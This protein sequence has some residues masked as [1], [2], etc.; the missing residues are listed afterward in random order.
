MSALSRYVEDYLRLRRALGFKL[1]REGQL[2]AQLVA[3]LETAGAATITTE[4]ATAWARQPAGVQPNHWAKRLGVV[5]KFAA[6]L[7]TIDPATEVPPPG[8]FPARRRRPTPY[9]WSQG[10]IC[11]LLEGARALRSPLRAATHEA[12]FGLLATSGMRVGEAIGLQRDDVGLGAGVITI[13]EA[14]FDRSRLVPLHPSATQALRRYAAERDRL[15]PRPRS[16]AFFLSSAG[17]ALDRSGVGKTFRK[18]TTAMGVRTAAT[19]PRVHDLRH[20][21]AVHTL[22]EWQRSGV[23]IDEHIAVLSTYLGHV[24]PAGTYWYLSAS[25]ELMELAAERLCERFGAGR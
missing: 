18:V 10:D 4:L 5:R 13:R 20:S 15:C 3:Y 12:L 24:T 11:R 25:P 1:E 6:Y 22:I 19:H 8:V 9:L 2:L 17:T 21:F 7:Q 16:S 23:N 14:K